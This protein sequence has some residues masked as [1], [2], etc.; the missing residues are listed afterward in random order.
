ME[1]A[2]AAILVDVALVLELAGWL[3]PHLG[4]VLQALAVVPLAAL[5]WRRRPRAVVL[6]TGAGAL[7]AFLV[8]VMGPGITVICSGVAVQIIGAGLRRGW[9]PGRITLTSLAA[10]GAPLAGITVGALALL[11]RLRALSLAQIRLDWRGLA[12]VLQWL[13]A[14]PALISAGGT[15]VG[16]SITH[17]WAVIPVVVLAF[18]TWVALCAYLFAVPVLR[19]LAE[20][21][22]VPGDGHE[23][24]PGGPAP[25]PGE[26]GGPP[27]PVPVHLDGV[28]YRYPGATIDA[29]AQVSLTVAPGSFVAVVGPNGSGKST[30]A[31]LLAGR[32]DPVSGVLRRPGDAGL[33]RVGGTATVAQRPESQVIGV[34]VA[35]DVAWGLAPG[36]GVDPGPLLERVGLG[37]LEDRETTTLSGGQLQRLAVAAALARRPSLLVADEATAMLDPVGRRELT[38]LLGD[39]A[40]RQG[41]ATVLVTHHPDEAGQAD[42]VVHLEHGRVRDVRPGEGGPRPGKVGLGARVA[43]GGDGNGSRPARG[44][45]ASAAAIALEDVGHVYAPRSPWA[46]RALAGVDLAV[47]PGEAVLVVG[48]NGSGKSTLAWILAGLVAP[49]EGRVLGGPDQARPSEVGIAFQHARLQVVRP[50][51]GRD[52]AWGTDLDHDGVCEAL[53]AVGLDPAEVLD[54]RPDSLSG[55]Q[56]RRVALAGLLARRPAVVVLDEPLAGLDQ[57][58]AATLTAVLRRLRAE[59]QIATIVVSHDLEDP[60]GLADRLVVLEAGRVVA[61]RVLA[62]DSGAGDP[63]RAERR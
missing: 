47:A 39:L 20:A 38:A 41:I 36:S 32:L 9:G 54:R 8:G 51:V 53:E 3:M 15:F 44:G 60:A 34:R 25:G 4:T 18:I 61:D 58:G 35:D 13:H 37:G 52:V 17:W 63:S 10:V 24:R 14:P 26:A 46:H 43:L 16:W 21:V 12:R 59:H 22:P 31:R 40:R 23:P 29:L 2:E 45:D 62:P 42:Q 11:P 7:L 50:T 56:L 30:L 1:L 5:A 19:R 6:G 33:G 57:E 27:E 55:G 48:P 49:T 28:S